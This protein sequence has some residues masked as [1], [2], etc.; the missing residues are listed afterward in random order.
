M[1]GSRQRPGPDEGALARARRFLGRVIDTVRGNERPSDVPPP[2]G[3][4][5]AASSE[6]LEGPSAAERELEPTPAATVDERVVE[7]P[8]AEALPAPGDPA[9]ALLSDASWSGLRAEHD[10][11]RTLLAWRDLDADADTLRTV[12]IHCD[13]GALDAA[14]RV[15]VRDHPA[16]GVIGARTLEGDAARIVV[17]LGRLRDGEFVSAV[18]ATVR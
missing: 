3:A 13:F 1:S 7:E 9:R 6:L 8:A 5:A 11:G 18:H 10:E 17:S 16:S 12:E 2:P 15:V 14:P 4:R